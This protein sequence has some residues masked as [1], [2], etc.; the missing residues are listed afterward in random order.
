MR[1]KSG[2]TAH[3]RHRKVRQQTRGMQHA[4]RT[5]FGLGKQ[6]IIRSLQYAYRDRRQRKRDHRQLWTV[7][8][9]A[10]ARQH[11]LTYSRLIPQLKKA[12]IE[13]DRKSLAEL[14]VN[15]PQAFTAVVKQSGTPKTSD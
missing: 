15:E 7:R 6:A 2:V 3:A 5:R 12:R 10:A 1:V 8:I 11:G 13:L 4:R 14:A 9:N